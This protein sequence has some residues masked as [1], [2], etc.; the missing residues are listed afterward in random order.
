MKPIKGAFFILFFFFLGLGLV[1][2]GT[3]H[4]LPEEVSPTPTATPS[5]T[6]TPKLDNCCLDN[7]HQNMPIVKPSSEP[8]QN[9]STTI[10]NNIIT[11]QS[12]Q[13]EPDPVPTPEPTPVPQ[14]TPTP[15][16]EVCL[17]LLGCVL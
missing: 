2:W 16:L 5:A 10:N 12:P 14:P 3:T 15:N 6:L 11:E 17:P 9:G 4:D 8:A 7:T 1:I 13:S